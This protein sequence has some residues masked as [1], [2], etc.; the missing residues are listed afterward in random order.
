MG[1]ETFFSF[2]NFDAMN[3]RINESLDLPRNTER[4]LLT[5]I[6]VEYPEGRQELIQDISQFQIPRHSA[7]SV[8]RFNVELTLQY[9]VQGTPKTVSLGSL[10]MTQAI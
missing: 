6:L 2:P 10:H 7:Y 3:L 1:G 5:G 9:S 4:L 8:T